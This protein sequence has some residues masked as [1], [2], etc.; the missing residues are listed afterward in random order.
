MNSDEIVDASRI[1]AAADRLRGHAHLT[2][3][4]TSVT[5]DQRVGARIL[6]KC[7]SFQRAGAFKFRGAYNAIACLSAEQRSRG[8]AT[9]SSGN[10][11][12]AVSLAAREFGV[13]AVILMPADAP[14]SKVAAVRSY[15]GEVVTY[16]RYTEDRKA[17]GEQLAAAGGM[18]L[19]PP[20]EHPDVI[21]GQGTVGLELLA[22]AA[23]LDAVVAPMGGGGLMAGVATA[24]RSG[25]PGAR[26]IGV[27]PAAGNDHALSLAAGERVR[28][29][30]PRTIADGLAVDCPGE[31]TFAINRRLVDEV[32]VVTDEEIVAAMRFLFDRMKLVV[33]PSGA[34]SVAAL[35]SA[36]LSLG[37]LRVGVVISG[38]NVD[39][40]RFVDLIGTVAGQGEVAVPA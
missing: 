18:A 11:G 6:V 27:E 37:G 7:E 4:L 36:R 34:A 38:G 29:P 17:L 5:L 2:P 8:V 26:V 14:A 28:I 15:G 10:H 32:V 9:Y 31:L 16:D 21:A 39:T 3:V 22:Q 24:V 20:Y 33:E 35:L 19:I 40:A 1:E 13:R 30:M 25:Q 23:S 12:Q